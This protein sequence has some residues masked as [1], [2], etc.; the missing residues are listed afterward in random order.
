MEARSGGEERR[1]NVAAPRRWR[2]CQSADAS[3]VDISAAAARRRRQGG[4]GAKCLERMGRRSSGSKSVSVRLRAAHGAETEMG[5]LIV[6]S[7]HMYS[8]LGPAHIT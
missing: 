5:F 2:R 6:A 7:A 1:Q 8:Y 3:A 4:G